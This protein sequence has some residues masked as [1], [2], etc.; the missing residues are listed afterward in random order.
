MGKRKIRIADTTLRDGQQS[1][2]LAFSP[3]TS[4]RMMEM[5]DD[6]GVSRVE[7]ATPP[8]GPGEF[9]IVRDLK[10]RLK[11][12]KMVSWNR[13]RMSDAEASL[14]LEPH[15][16]HLCFPVSE[17]QLRK[18]LKISF[19]EA[20]TLLAELVETVAGAGAEVSVGLEDV[21][22]AT[23]ER[24]A[25]AKALLRKLRVDNLR[26][27]DTVGILTP[28]RTAALVEFFRGEKY[29]LEFHAHNDLG[30]AVP[31]SLMAALS[32]ADHIDTT[33]LGVGERAGNA[34]LSGFLRLCA[35]S[36][37]LETDVDLEEALFLEET[38]SSL[39][40]R[41]EYLDSL[42]NSPAS[43]ITEFAGENV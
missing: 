40:N 32:G 31:N 22:R 2:G 28:G 26:L 42:M 11:N 6:L 43:D 8:A 20:G 23:P 10:C 17:P 38:F 36:P 39:L 12:A 21:S 41:D 7:V 9:Q 16:V 33:L 30:M 35:M 18:K 24:L 29:A 19:D 4:L 3:E 15:A 27:S 25:E 34:S 37:L 14:R 13:L 5:L 1:P